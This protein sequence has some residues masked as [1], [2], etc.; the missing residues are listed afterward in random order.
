M[1]SLQHFHVVGMVTS[2][3][4]GER[5]CDP[6]LWVNQLNHCTSSAGDPGGL[7]PQPNIQ[8]SGVP[9]TWF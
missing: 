1:C 7:S 6:K 4:W 5:P 3:S 2:Y 8:A 9:V